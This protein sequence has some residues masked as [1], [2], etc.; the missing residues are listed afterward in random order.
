MINGFFRK[1]H[2]A[3]ELN[4]QVQ[5]KSLMALH[6]TNNTPEG[7]VPVSGTVTYLEG[8]SQPLL[9]NMLCSLINDH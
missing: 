7:G 2:M 1:L 8:L 5:I 6:T 9:F 4:I 3:V